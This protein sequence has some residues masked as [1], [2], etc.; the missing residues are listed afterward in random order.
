MNIKDKNF[1]I[2]KDEDVRKLLIANGLTEMPSKN[3][4]LFVFINEP[5]KLT[6]DFESL[7]VRFTNKLYF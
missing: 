5:K 3:G 1:V 7:P 2:T 4:D 6:F